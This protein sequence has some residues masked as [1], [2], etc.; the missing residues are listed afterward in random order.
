MIKYTLE[1]NIQWILEA[2]FEASKIKKTDSKI[3]FSDILV[4]L[5]Y[6]FINIPYD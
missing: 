5:F 2:L 3:K 6:F 1:L 4:L